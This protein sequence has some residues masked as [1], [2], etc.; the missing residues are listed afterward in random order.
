MKHFLLVYDREE[1]RLVDDPVEFN[2]Y[3]DALNERFKRERTKPPNHEI[4]VLSS[5]SRA[6]LEKTHARYFK[7][8]SELA[9]S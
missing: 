6:N 8:V 1:G 2:D 9:A 3:S 7:S 5:S 4:V